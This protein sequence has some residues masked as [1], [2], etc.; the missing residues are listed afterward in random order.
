M[1]PIQG[2][3]HLQDVGVAR[4]GARAGGSLAEM[5][6]ADIYSGA[7]A[8]GM[9][10]KQIDLEE[11]YGCT[12]LTL[13]H[14]LDQ[15]H[16]RKIVQR[17]PNRGYYVPPVDQAYVKNI[18]RARALV[19]MSIVDELVAN[20]TSESLA[21]LSYLASVF[22]DTVRTGT[23]VEQDSANHDFHRELLKACHNPVM[24]E[25]IWDL[26]TR[27]PLAVQRANNT[28]AKLEQAARDH[29]EMIEALRTK[30]ADRMRAIT[31]RH[32]GMNQGTSA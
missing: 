26:R 5:I 18:F 28:P 2:V 29:F 19:E 8:P 24:V 27:V 1:F 30:D 32:V 31:E 21:R 10:L 11:R 15:L 7:L 23:V 6:E 13:R 3:L 9:W 22:A 17:I 12:R 14:A 20:V 25:I 4:G 16:S